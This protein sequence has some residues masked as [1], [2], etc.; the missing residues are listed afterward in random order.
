MCFEVE[1]T[2]E[3]LFE[4][5]LPYEAL[6]DRLLYLAKW[7]VLTESYQ[8]QNVCFRRHIKAGAGGSTQFL[9]SRLC[10]TKEG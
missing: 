1:R 5:A 3:I 10:W 4:S 7:T 6:K 8:G 9:I 2:S